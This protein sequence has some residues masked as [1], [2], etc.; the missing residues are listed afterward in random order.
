MPVCSVRQFIKSG[1][2]VL[3]YDTHA[4]IRNK[5]TGAKIRCVMENDMYY[6][7]IKVDEPSLFVPDSGFARQ[8]R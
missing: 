5:N 2:E 4:L 1:N 7:K 3:F 8:A 6:V